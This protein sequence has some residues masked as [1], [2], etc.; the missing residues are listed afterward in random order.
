MPLKCVNREEKIGRKWY[1]FHMNTF[2]KYPFL[3]KILFLTPLTRHAPS[4]EKSTLFMRFF[5]SRMCTL[6]YLS[7]PPGVF[8]VLHW[9]SMYYFLLHWVSKFLSI[10]TCMQI[11]FI[12]QYELVLKNVFLLIG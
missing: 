8:L 5:W 1:P 10:C 12:S 6:L 2:Q 7:A 9:I 4:Y 11:C 3:P